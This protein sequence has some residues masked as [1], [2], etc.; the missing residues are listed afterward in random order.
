MISDAVA[1]RPRAMR[2]SLPKGMRKFLCPGKHSNRTTLAAQERAIV[3]TPL[4]FTILNLLTRMVAVRRETGASAR[5]ILS[6][7]IRCW[8]T[9]KPEVVETEVGKRSAAI[10]GTQEFGI[11]E[12]RS[13]AQSVHL[14]GFRPGRIQFR[15]THIIFPRT[16]RSPTPRRCP[17]SRTDQTDLHA[18]ARLDELCSRCISRT[19]QCR[20]AHDSVMPNFPR[21]WGGA[22]R[23]ICRNRWLRPRSL[24]TVT[25]CPS[26][27][28]PFGDRALFD[29]ARSLVILA[30]FS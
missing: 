15:A 3:F 10:R 17:T 23:P 6:T 25:A 16:N 5:D 24:T 1:A 22:R 27:G 4:L 20:Q 13:T 21:V 26:C 14:S 12:P 11:V 8:Y 28:S 7:T 9:A 18:F 30:T 29:V 2:P 19:T